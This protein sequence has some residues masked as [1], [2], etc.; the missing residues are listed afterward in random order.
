MKKI[1]YVL[2]VLFLSLTVINV[3]AMESYI[4]DE[5]ETNGYYINSKGV[6]INNNLYTE[7]KDYYSDYDI[8]NMTSSVYDLL[9]TNIFEKG[10]K[11]RG[12]DEKYVETTYLEKIDGTITN[13][14]D[15]TISEEEYIE[16]STIELLE[17][18]GT[19]CWKTEYKAV[20]IVDFYNG[21]KIAMMLENTWLKMPKIRKFD[22][23][24]LRWDSGFNLIEYTGTQSVTTTKKEEY[25]Y[26]KGNDH[27]KIASN[28]IGLS[29]NIVDAAKE[30]NNILYIE[31]TCTSSTTFYGTYQHAT[32]NN[33]TLAI[34]K[35]YSFSSLGLGRVL[36]FSNKTYRGYYDSM[37]GVVYKHR[38]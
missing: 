9:L 5:M 7:I 16:K 26:T 31:G 25:F 36:Y 14:A 20:R 29:M 19:A 15:R 4:Q 6:K 17:S 11:I 24:A 37:E 30:I 8:E 3:N 12:I 34:S 1:F 13:I 28:G 18:C 35:S 23:I 32:S 38:L 2:G 10:Y 22:I 21:N 27:Y 33:V